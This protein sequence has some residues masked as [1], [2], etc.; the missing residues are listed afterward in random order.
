MGKIIGFIV[1]VAIVCFIMG[2]GAS[3]FFRKKAVGFW[4]NIQAEPVNDIKKY[5]Y[6][7]GKLFMAYGVVFN[8]LGIPLLSGQNSPLILLSVIGILIETIVTMAIY[9]LVIAR[10]YRTY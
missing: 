9:T 8:I 5:N 10:K 4:A 2:I 3:A 6:A 1:W 7:V